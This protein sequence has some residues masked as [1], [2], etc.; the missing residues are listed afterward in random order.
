[1]HW[2]RLADSGP[3]HPESGAGPGVARQ[4]P[5]VPPLLSA[6]GREA[7]LLPQRRKTLLQ[8]GLHQ[9]M[10]QPF[11]LQFADLASSLVKIFVRILVKILEESCKNLRII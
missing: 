3:V 1:M 9:V 5:Q 11:T 2:V 4:L 7:D 10:Y 8:T 6:A